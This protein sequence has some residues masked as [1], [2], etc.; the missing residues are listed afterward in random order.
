MDRR[1]IIEMTAKHVRDISKTANAG[2]DWWHTYRVWKTALKIAEQE[3]KTDLFV[4]QLG[5]L[6]HDIADWKFSSGRV[7][8]K[9]Q[10]KKWLMKTGADKNT[11]A[12]VNYIINSVTFRGARVKDDVRNKEAAIVQDADRLDALG[13]IGI[14]RAFAYGGY[15][16]RPM[17]DP[18]EKIKLH[19]N[20]R[21]YRLSQS[22]STIN[23]FYEKLLLL[24]KRMKTRTGRRIAKERDAFIRE[25]LDRFLEEWKGEE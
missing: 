1:R 24:R 22:E 17:Y 11:I 13:A 15:K 6:M 5:A 21:A 10:V 20:F 23:H 19:D 3:G 7:S 2:H 9:V 18:S 12:K 16:R 25:Y 8:E 14:A 4:V